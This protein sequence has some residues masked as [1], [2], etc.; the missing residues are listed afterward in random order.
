LID[1]LSLFGYLFAYKNDNKFVY[2]HRPSWVRWCQICRKSQRF[3]ISVWLS[4]I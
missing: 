3:V 2:T 4:I 1:I